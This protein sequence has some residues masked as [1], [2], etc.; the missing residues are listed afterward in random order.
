[1]CKKKL[2]SNT[3]KLKSVLLG[4]L[5]STTPNVKWLCIL[6]RNGS[7]TERSSKK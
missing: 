5:S 1:M 3:E 2:I 7:K 6:C 4:G